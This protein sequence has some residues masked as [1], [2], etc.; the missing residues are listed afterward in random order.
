MKKILTIV[1][2]T[3]ALVLLTACSGDEGEIGFFSRDYLV[4]CNIEDFPL[5]V[6]DAEEMRWSGE[7][8][9]LNLGDEE[10][11]EYSRTVMEYLLANENIYYKGYHYETGCPGGIF[12]LPEYRFAPLFEDSDPST[13]WYAF[14]LTETLNEGDE[15]N[16][17]YWNGVVVRIYQKDGTCGSFSYNTV[18]N[19]DYE[20]AFC[21]YNIDKHD[22]HS[23]EYVGN[24]Y[25]HQ[26][27]Y[28]CG[29]DTP[30]IAEMHIDFDEDG[31]CDLC[32]N[33]HKHV[34]GIWQY[35]ESIHWCGWDCLWD[36]C[37][38]DTAAE[39][40]DADED[41]RCDV[42]EYSMDADSTDSEG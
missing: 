40:V 38:I 35:D 10:A 34:F 13:G 4:Q 21:T 15:F 24:D 1:L 8:V 14:S 27:V 32:S 23:S 42:C 6:A 29:C 12:Y 41:R 36:A 19:I 33:E 25:T 28:T 7:K 31:Y 37:D 22:K 30:D 20:A 3:I 11:L 16:R 5:P 2:F 9:Y 18:I 26:R 17:S 39:H